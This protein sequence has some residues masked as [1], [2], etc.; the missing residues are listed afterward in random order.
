[1]VDN[2]REKAKKKGLST[3]YLTDEELFNIIE[4][5]STMST[6]EETDEAVFLDIE[7]G[8]KRNSRGQIANED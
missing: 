2:Y 7:E 6:S 5:W 1:M 8:V 4:T 3:D